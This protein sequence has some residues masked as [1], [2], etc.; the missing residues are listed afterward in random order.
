MIIESTYTAPSAFHAK[1]VFEFEFFGIK[2]SD[3]QN[4]VEYVQICRNYYL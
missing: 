4:S 3:T 1:S 2:N